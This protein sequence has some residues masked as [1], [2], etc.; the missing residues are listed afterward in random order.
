MWGGSQIN[1]TFLS[2]F[3]IH[4]QGRGFS[5][6]RGGMMPGPSVLLP[7]QFFL[8]RLL[9]GTKLLFYLLGRNKINQKGET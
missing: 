6:D 3:V 1:M 7:T 2:N 4:C 9:H 5:R 8:A